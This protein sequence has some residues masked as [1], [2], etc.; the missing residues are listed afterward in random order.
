MTKEM[1][2]VR[3]PGRRKRD[4]AAGE[5]RRRL[6]GPGDERP[7]AVQSLPRKVFYAG[8]MFRYERPQKGRYRQF[9]QIGLEVLGGAGA[10]GGCRGDRLRMADPARRSRSTPRARCW[11]LNTLGDAGKLAPMPTG[12]RWSGT[13]GRIEDRPLARQPG[14]AGAS[15]PLR[16]LDSKNEGDR[17]I[18]ADAPTIQPHLTPAAAAFHDAV[19]GHLGRFGVPFRE[20]PRIVRGLDYYGHTAFEFVTTKLGAQ[21]TVMAGGRY[22]G[23][24][25]R[26]GRPPHPRRRLGRRHGAPGDAARQPAPPSRRRWPWFPWATTPRAPRS[27][28]SSPCAPPAYGPRWPTAAICAAG[29]ERANK[30]E[31]RAAVILGPDDVAAGVAQVKDLR[32]GA[33]EAV[34]LADIAA[35]LASGDGAGPSAGDVAGSSPGIGA[36]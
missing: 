3:G 23:L 8:P 21:G 24:G 16:I 26:D 34:P 17:R 22:D 15:N 12:R 2:V 7:D 29:F 14:P 13:S 11:R 27:A 9:H 35:R 10:A 33:Q 36:A 5:Y 30:I 20:N 4:A 31:A 32:T 28:F 18:V 1:Y 19:R 6:P 25:G